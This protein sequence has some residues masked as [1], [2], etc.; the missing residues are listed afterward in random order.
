M[1][2]VGCTFCGIVADPAR[3]ATFYEDD[4]AIGIL[5]LRQPGWPD[6]VHALV[7][8]RQHVE[9]LDDLDDETAG[10]LMRAVVQ[11]AR[12]VRAAFSPEG[13][14][15]WQSNGAAGGQEVPHVHLHVIT[16]R[17]GDGLL[18]IY[19]AAPELPTPADLD[20]VAER[21]RAVTPEVR[22]AGP[23]TDRP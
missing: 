6:A 2:T 7:I 15:L 23:P 17:A 13:Y 5:D 16:R 10:G 22:A 1:T 21:L 19:P 12:I 20:A 3:A 11:V 4:A 14:N 8:P 9:L 18:R